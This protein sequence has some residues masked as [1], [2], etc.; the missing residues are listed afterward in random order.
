MEVRL[1]R[2]VN[3]FVTKMRKLGYWR[4]L[5]NIRAEKEQNKQ[6]LINYRM[7]VECLWHSPKTKRL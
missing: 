2:L 6:G 7:G 1:Y 4:Y 5:D 3:F